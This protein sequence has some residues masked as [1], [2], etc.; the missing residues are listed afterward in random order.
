M[1]ISTQSLLL[2]GITALLFTLPWGQHNLT[3]GILVFVLVVSLFPLDGSTTTQL[4]KQPLIALPWLMMAWF[5]LSIAWGGNP[6]EG[7][8]QLETKLAFVVVPWIGFRVRHWIN[9]EQIQRWTHTWALGASAALIFVL[10]RATLMAIQAGQT[11]YVVPGT[12]VQ[13]SFFT[14]ETLTGP[15]MHPGYLA[16]HLGLAFWFVMLGSHNT[17]TKV[18]WLL[19]LFAGLFLVQ[20]RMNLLALLLTLALWACAMA[21]QRKHYGLLAVPAVSAVVLVALMTLGGK[22]LRDRYFQLPQLNYDIAAGPEGFNSATFRLAEWTCAWDVI[23]PHLWLG[24]GVGGNREALQQA[25]LQRG[26]QVGFDRHYNV[27]N[28]YLEWWLA[29]GLLGLLLLL[30]YALGLAVHLARK[31]PELFWPWLFLLLCGVTESMLERA[32]GVGLWAVYA[33]LLSWGV[34][35]AGRATKSTA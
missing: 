11:Y 31:R 26:F 7:F 19:A 15:L 33:G 13:V 30:A 12:D 32:W 5:A 23:Q 35:D 34:W 25:Y 2:K 6:T 14:Y 8:R 16:S 1:N 24:T 17:R 20:G 3:N 28:Q 18:L 9:P 27:H 4:W 29:T 21:W 22:S 10:G